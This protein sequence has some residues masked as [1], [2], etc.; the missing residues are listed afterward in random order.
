MD[1]SNSLTNETC[2]C[3]TTDSHKEKE[4]KPINESSSSTATIK[5]RKP[6]I[7][8][9]SFGFNLRR[10]RS[11]NFS[12]KRSKKNS[13]APVG[14]NVSALSNKKS[15]KW[16]MKLNCSKKDSKNEGQSCCQCTCY[17]RTGE[18]HLGA[19]VVFSNDEV[20][21]ERSV[22]STSIAHAAS[23]STEAVVHDHPQSN[24]AAAITQQTDSIN[25]GVYSN[26]SGNIILSAPLIDIHW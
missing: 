26:S 13:Q 3:E 21:Q 4:T 10:G 6:K 22:P 17:R 8:L 9:T 15:S 25:R 2:T 12:N 19:G 24:A 20:Q 11:L 7:S 5:E 14:T 18:H 23:T 1:A 16:V